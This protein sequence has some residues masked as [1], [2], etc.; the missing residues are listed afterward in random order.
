MT[1][2]KAI[3]SGWWFVLSQK[4]F[5]ET[6]FA[7]GPSVQAPHLAME[8]TPSHPSRWIPQFLLSTGLRLF[9]VRLV[10]ASALLTMGITIYDA[11]RSPTEWDHI[12]LIG[13]ASATCIHQVLA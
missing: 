13:S 2:L 8:P 5:L 12:L 1:E 9:Y 3:P 4:Y 11:Q 6:G 10:L 7:L